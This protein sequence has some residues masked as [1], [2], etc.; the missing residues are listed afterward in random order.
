MRFI[1]LILLFAVTFSNAITL[2]LNPS[3][4]MNFAWYDEYP[5]WVPNIGIEVPVTI[6]RHEFRAGLRYSPKGHRYDRD[7]F[8]SYWLHYAE[9]PLTYAYYP[10]LFRKKIGFYLGYSI[11][12]LFSASIEDEQGFRSSSS[13]KSMYSSFDHGGIVGIRYNQTI[14]KSILDFSVNYYQGIGTVMD[15]WDDVIDPK[16][17]HSFTFLIGFVIPVLKK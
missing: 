2:D 3:A 12:Y 16:R 5:I 7:Y 13:L 1:L 11:S 10:T 9:F 14:G 6:D 15:K 4:G 8:Y 17:N